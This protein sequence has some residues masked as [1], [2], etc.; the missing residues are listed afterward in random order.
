MRSPS[1][2]I[3]VMSTPKQVEIA[4]TG[5]CNLNCAYCFYAD[6]MTSRSDL[7]TPSGWVFS[8]P[9]VTWG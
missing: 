3:I 6:E 9:W 7:T 8:R 4:L 5:R 2:E 1:P